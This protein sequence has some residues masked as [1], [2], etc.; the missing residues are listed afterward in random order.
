MR[1]FPREKLF[2]V[3]IIGSICVTMRDQASQSQGAEAAR[4]LAES[5]KAF[6]AALEVRTREQFPQDWAATQNNLGNA[7]LDQ[8]SQS[9]GAEAARFLVEAVTSFRAALEVST[10]RQF[11][12]DWAATQN[13]LGAALNDQ[14]RLS[15]GAEA[16]RLLV[17]GSQPIARR[18][19]FIRASNTRR[20]GP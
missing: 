15:K 3:G 8:A 14:A 7:L 2:V 6:G 19:R 1:I 20:D 13:C 12:Q 11:P 5:V 4:L 10:R 16:V 9:Q 18:W 17:E